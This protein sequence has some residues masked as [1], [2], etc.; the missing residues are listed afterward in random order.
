M[1]VRRRARG[2]F[3]LAV[4]GVPLLAVS[5]DFATGRALLG[6]IGEVIYPGDIDVFEVRDVLWV[7]VFLVIGTVAVS[8]GIW[9]L[10]VP[11]KVLF[12][13][14]YGVMVQLR[15]VLHRNSRITWAQLEAV[16]EIPYVFDE[17][18]TDGIAF[19][20]S[21]HAT[22]SRNPWGGRWGD[23]HTLLLD[24]GSWD[25]PVAEVVNELSQRIGVQGPTTADGWGPAL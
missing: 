25:T 5:Y 8:W 24:A 20:L 19:T 16:E 12:V 18:A 7:S 17:T 13:D 14:Q 9:D 1:I 10:A 3:W 22:L 21:D 6:R 15:G 2:S 11:R 23:D 4:L